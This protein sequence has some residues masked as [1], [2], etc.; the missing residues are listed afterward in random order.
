MRVLPNL[1]LVSTC[2]STLIGRVQSVFIQPNLFLFK[3]NFLAKGTGN[4]FIIH[5]SAT[6]T[7]TV[8]T[9]RTNQKTAVSHIESMSLLELT[10]FSFVY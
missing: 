10:Y 2:K 3:V 6:V 5:G 1:S 9:D 8:E 7:K 4:A